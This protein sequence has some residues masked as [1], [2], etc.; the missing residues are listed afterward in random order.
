VVLLAKSKPSTSVSST[1]HSQQSAAGNKKMGRG[2]LV[3]IEICSFEQDHCFMLAG[4]GGG[5][6]Y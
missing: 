2:M 1:M 3:R 4:G 6:K 5:I